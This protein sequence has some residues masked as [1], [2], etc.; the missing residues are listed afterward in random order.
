LAANSSTAT[1]LEW[2]DDAQNTVIDA[3]GDLLVG[4]SADTLARLP[5]G[6][7]GQ[8][9]VADSNQTYGVGW[10]EVNTRNVLYN[11]AMQVHQRGTSSTSITGAGYYTADRWSVS[12]SSLGTWTQTIEN[13]APTGSGFRKSLKMLCT[14]A[15]AAPA[16]SDRMWIEQALEG[17][18]LQAFRKGTAQAQQMTLSFWVKSNN[19]GTYTVTILDSD[20]SRMTSFSYVISASATWQFKT[21][22][23]PADTIGAFD[24]DNNASLYVTF[25]LGAGSDW[26]SGTLQ[27]SWAAITNANRNAGQT[28]LAAAIN[29]YW[30]ITGVQLNVGA[31]AAPFEFKKYGQELQECQ[32]YYEASGSQSASGDYYAVNAKYDTS[33]AWYMN[34]YYKVTKRIA[35]TPTV[36]TSGTF[37]LIDRK[38]VDGFNLTWST[39][40]VLFGFKVDAEL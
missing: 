28:N 16:A 3:K 37:T 22:T 34:V 15:D 27:S 40:G 2:I 24:N 11:G 13:D 33:S 23:I 39:Q 10:S 26:T 1:G 32:R 29:N 36:W 31:V 12:A 19:I 18:D 14:A 17:Q 8:M 21:I 6:S 4:A 20:N 30:Q 38:F 25:G 7:N 5:V 35:A 9:L